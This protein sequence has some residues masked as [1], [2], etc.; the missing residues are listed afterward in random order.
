M[1][2]NVKEYQEN[3]LLK[4]RYTK[5]MPSIMYSRP[6]WKDAPK[7]AEKLVL[8]I[9]DGDDFGKWMWILNEEYDEKAH[10]YV[11]DRPI[12]YIENI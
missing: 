12:E 3:Q 9:E 4:L 2:V 7:I 8:N 10:V 1:K 6:D 5:D 11:E